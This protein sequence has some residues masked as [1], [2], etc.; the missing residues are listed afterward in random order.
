MT[1]KIVF[2]SSPYAGASEKTV[3]VNVEFAKAACRYAIGKGYTP[4]APHL[5]YPGFLPDDDPAAREKGLAM[6]LDFLPFCA[7]L[8]VCGSVISSG[9]AAEIAAAKALG[10]WVCNVSAEKIL[11]FTS[12]H[13]KQTSETPL[14]DAR[15]F[16]LSSQGI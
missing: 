15:R 10:I 5:L 13:L 7:E 11:G 12:A 3:R 2:I 16:L 4:F 8:W 9:M 1:S 14:C 6:G